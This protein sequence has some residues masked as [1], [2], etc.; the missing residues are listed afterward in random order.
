MAPPNTATPGEIKSTAQPS[1]TISVTAPSL[2]RRADHALTTAYV[3]PPECTFNYGLTSLTAAISD[4][5]GHAEETFLY[6]PIDGN[7]LWSSC[8]PTGAVQG[9]QNGGGLHVAPASVYR[10]AVCPSGWVAFE[11]GMGSRTPTTTVFPK[12]KAGY[13]KTLAPVTWSTARCCKR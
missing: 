4:S 2:A 12:G 6:C 1:P 5:F 11:V 7:D 13:Y 9:Y 10:G 8:Q 3:F